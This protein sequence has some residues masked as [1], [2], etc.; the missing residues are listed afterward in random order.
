MER[1][2]VGAAELGVLS[3]ML[4]KVEFF[5]PLTV[6]QLDQVLPHVRI[7]S[8]SPGEKVFSQGDPGDAFY[9]VYKGSVEVRLS[10]LLFLSKKV[11][12]LREGDFFGETALVSKEP[13][14][15]TIVAAEPAL[16]FALI[17]DD[18]QF[19]LNEN[20]AAAQEMKRVAVRRKFDSAHS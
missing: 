16:L 7:H 1:L 13:R 5:A 6:G 11:A 15:A 14:N 3:R 18:F 8:F 9:I 20:P 19:V 4:R 17:A 10:R 12:T 2:E